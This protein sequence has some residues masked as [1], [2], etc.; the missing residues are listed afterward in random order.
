MKREVNMASDIMPVGVVHELVDVALGKPTGFGLAV[1]GG[2][3]GYQEQRWYFV[4]GEQSEWPP[5]REHML[6]K[7]T[8]NGWTG[9]TTIEKFRDKAKVELKNNPTT[10]RYAAV[11]CM[12]KSGIPKLPDPMPTAKF[13]DDLKWPKASQ[14]DWGLTQLR[15]GDIVAGYVLAGSDDRNHITEHW[16]LGPGYALGQGKTLDVIRNGQQF[17]TIMNGQFWND[18][19]TLVVCACAYTNDFNN[20]TI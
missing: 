2:L 7:T 16:Y 20:V 14:T 18:N 6:R 4:N 3:D 9:M 15:T 13:L 5:H 10:A 1:A 11:N 12:Q 8:D 19:C 17:A